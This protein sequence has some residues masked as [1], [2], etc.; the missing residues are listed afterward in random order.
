M[1][2]DA[3]DWSFC[4]DDALG[5]CDTFHPCFRFVSFRMN[6]G[7]SCLSNPMLLFPDTSEATSMFSSSSSSSDVCRLRHGSFRV[8]P[9][10]LSLLDR[11]GLRVSSARIVGTTPRCSVTIGGLS[12]ALVSTS[13]STRVSAE[14]SPLGCSAPVVS[15]SVATAEVELIVFSTAGG[16]GISNAYKIPE[17]LDR[18][19]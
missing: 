9:R 5:A 2:L 17:R 8:P 1:V 10:L 16:S 19:F 14:V 13:T 18:T 7:L 3:A 6:R 4:S 12:A 15:L 11:L